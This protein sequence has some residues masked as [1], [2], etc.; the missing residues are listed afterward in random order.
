MSI[1]F[2]WY[3]SLIYIKIFI[4]KG[5]KIMETNLN[6]LSDDLYNLLLLLHKKVINPDET[7]KNLSMPSSHFKVI[8]YL[9][10]KG[11]SSVSDIC[12]SLTISRPNMTPI[13]DKL[14]SDGMVHRYNDTKDRRIVRVEL[15][16][17]AHEFVREQEDRMK[18]ILS[19]K[20]STLNANDLESLKY[21]V[22]E[23]INILM[24]I[25]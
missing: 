8:F 5:V 25:E 3:N 11:T 22:E 13:I 7:M 2:L 17:K 6:K 10:K 19:N 18:K 14:I 20:I 9:K 23:I 24:K 4:E 1:T 15:T 16:N 12:N 21:N